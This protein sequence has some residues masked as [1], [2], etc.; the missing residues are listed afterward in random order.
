MG[1]ARGGHGYN[2]HRRRVS[3]TVPVGPNGLVG[4]LQR[5]LLPMAVI[6]MTDSSVCMARWRAST[7]DH[8]GGPAYYIMLPEPLE[9]L[10]TGINL[11]HP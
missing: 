5:G 8:V 4:S 9:G 10:L 6:G 2:V 11:Y 3:T 1:T 7:L